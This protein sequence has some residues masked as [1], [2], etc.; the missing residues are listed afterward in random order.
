MIGGQ[1]IAESRLPGWSSLF[2]PGAEGD[3][4][5]SQKWPDYFTDSRSKP[6]CKAGQSRPM[7]QHG[8]T[9]GQ[10]IVRDQKWR[11]LTCIFPVD[12]MR[13]FFYSRRLSTRNNKQRGSRLLVEDI[14]VDF[15]LI[16]A[17]GREKSL[18]R[19]HPWIFSG[20][21][22][23]VKGRP[24]S[25]QTVDVISFNGTWL[26]KAA[27]SPKSQIQGRVW[28]FDPTENVDENFF[29]RRIAA[30]AQRRSLLIDAACTGVRLVH[31]ES[32][33][34]PGLIVDRYA[35]VLV[36][37]IL[38]AGCEFWREAII[39][40]LRS[41]WPECSILERSDVEVRTKEGLAERIETVH[42]IIPDHVGIAE[43]GLKLA[44]DVHFGHKT[45]FYLDQRDSRLAVGQAVRGIPDARVLN[46]FSYTGG[47]GLAALGGGAAH[48]TQLDA[49][50]AALALAERNRDVNCFAPERMTTICGDAF[51]ILRAWHKEGRTFDLIVLDPPKFVDS[52]ASLN[53][54]ARG[55]K[56][57]N[58][59]AFRLLAPGGRLFTFS[60]S[61]LMDDGLFQKIV[62]DAALDAGRTARIVRRLTQAPDHP[63]DLAFPEGAYLKG[64]EVL[65]D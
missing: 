56:D 63:V 8:R 1:R 64:L 40:A 59:C 20:A 15:Q 13:P 27:F 42:G 22:A 58:L 11:L 14:F 9:H 32:D 41:L 21:V 10:Q 52:K 46:C 39:A 43:N 25:G 53:R 33:G 62:S 19:H 38:T 49:S 29:M 50:A 2:L 54:A 47:F 4:V 57:V 44:V 65:A 24:K 16:I 3:K 51:Q 17:T 6:E 26:A 18:L 34:L 7:D 60:C 30:A 45:G 12:C 61:G 37:Q 55:Y 28:T 23:T 35:E 36:F 31:S 5:E 48:V